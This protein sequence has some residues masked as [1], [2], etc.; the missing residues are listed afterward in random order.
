[1]QC[2]QFDNSRKG[3]AFVKQYIRV[4]EYQ[5]RLEKNMLLADV[6]KELSK[7]KADL[8]EKRI[9]GSESEKEVVRDVT[10][11]VLAPALNGFV[12]WVLTESMKQGIRRLY[13]LARD[14]YFMY[15]T[16]EFYVKE[17]GLPIE[18]KYLYC[19]R[20][21]IRIPNYHLDTEKAL[22]YITLG[23]LDITAKK[24]YK[25]A[26]FNREQRRRM[27]EE[28]VLPLQKEE[29]IPREQ[30]P[31]IKRRLGE[32]KGF[33]DMLQ[34]NSYKAFPIYEQYL[35]QEGLLEEIPMAL[36]DS[37]WVGSMQKELNL[38]L[39]KLGKK[40][41][42]KGFYW[43]LYEL[44]QDTQRKDYFTYFF[45]PEGE[46]KRKTSFNNCLFESIFTAP[47]GMTLGY[48][49]GQDK[50][51]PIFSEISEERK[52][53]LVLME[54][55]IKQWQKSFLKSV[56]KMPDF[57]V[58]EQLGGKEVLTIIEKNMECFMHHP[59]KAEASA[60]GEVEFTDDILEYRGNKIATY[61][62]EK[63]LAQNHFIGKLWTK[64]S[65]NKEHVRQSAWY[66]GSAVVY[67]KHPEYHIF[68]YSCYKYAMNYR[69]QAI[70]RRRYE[71][72]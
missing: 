8:E 9:A 31:E 62:N 23:G 52:E 47:H 68:H 36:V 17:F 55:T 71:G 2:F 53:R 61:L 18:C 72:N 59:T 6:A 42:L 32:N 51:C 58:L 60:F 35:K 22:D 65:G 13:F 25:R 5:K 30:L 57:L 3:G 69:K 67:G 27:Y 4:K 1:M 10:N 29:Q 44:P 33:M 7:A 15:R 40:E 19:S 70:W 11:Y 48:E 37:G 56:R 20:Y 34:E 45:S 41:P 50:I 39:Q 14:G 66:E 43:G 24:L 64:V 38:S 63:E 12:A 49:K 16:A 46:M 28:G 26:G 54:E 21:S